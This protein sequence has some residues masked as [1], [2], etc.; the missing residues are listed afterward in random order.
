M[1]II[2]CAFAGCSSGGSK[3]ETTSVPITQDPELA[4]DKAV[5]KES[6]AIDFIKS[7]YSEKELGLDKTKED[8][9]L[10]IASNATVINKEKYVNVV[11]NVRHE[12]DVTAQDGA[13]T[14][15]FKIVGS[16]FISFD[17][18]KILKKDLK[19]GKYQELE[20]RYEQFKKESK[21]N[22]ETTVK[23]QPKKETTKK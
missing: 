6:E 10:M 15:T 4:T 11:A 3:N 19:N 17:G 21:K 7:S 14:Y 5:I 2:A 8:Y 12:S 18:K 16:Y 20:N 1:L 22:G 23:A 13:K 9:S